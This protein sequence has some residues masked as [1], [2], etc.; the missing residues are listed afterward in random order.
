MM[1]I[2]LHQYRAIRKVNFYVTYQDMKQR[3]KVSD[4]IRARNLFLDFATVDKVL[5][6]GYV[7][8]KRLDLA[9]C[10]YETLTLKHGPVLYSMPHPSGLNRCWNYPEEAEKARALLREFTS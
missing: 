6:L 8:L 4:S 7:V 9:L 1:D 3:N 5:L 10:P 2:S